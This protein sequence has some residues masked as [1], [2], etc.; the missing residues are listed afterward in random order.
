MGADA[1]V[2]LVT[3]ASRGL[4]AVIAME[5]AMHG[6][7]VAVNYH[8]GIDAARGVVDAIRRVGGVAEAFAAD[9]TDEA[10]VSRLVEQVSQRLG[11]IDVLVVN[12]TGP[13]PDVRVEDLTW[14]AH[15]DQLVYFVKS[16]TL[17]VRAVLPQMKARRHGRIIQIGSDSFE[18][19][20]PGT[21]AYVA[22]KGAQLGLTR[23]WARELGTHNITV[24]L[25]A[26]GWI[27]VERHS[28]IA[29]SA[30]EEYIADVP[31]GRLGQPADVAAAVSF[32]ASEAAAFINGER[33]SVNGGHTIR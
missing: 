7:A 23:A 9:V 18:R 8:S 21:S 28:D 3:G 10:G 26:P 29:E 15:L 13:Q 6:R 20:L 19:A 30:F 33:I 25:I 32:L 31:L 1:G 22:A 17:L 24:N 5:L 16:P 11:P 27:P 14:Q 12:A 2:A 4:G